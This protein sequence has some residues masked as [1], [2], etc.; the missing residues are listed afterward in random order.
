MTLKLEMCTIDCADPALLS[1]FWQEAL[2]YTEVGNFGGEYIMLAPADG[3]HGLR[4]G[5]QRVPEELAGKNSVHLD[6]SVPDRE[7]EVQRLTGLGA[8]EIARHEA[9][10]FNWVVLTD[11]EHNQFCVHQS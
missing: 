8:K 11:P 3:S 6:F 5:L 4:M 10:G 7:A 9:D 1:A 2:G